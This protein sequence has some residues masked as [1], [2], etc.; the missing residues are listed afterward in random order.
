[1]NVW[2]FLFLFRIQTV[3]KGRK[4]CALILMEFG[5]GKMA[6]PVCKPATY[7]EN[8]TAVYKPAMYNENII[9]GCKPA[10]FSV[11]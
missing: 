10:M 5:G 1:M 7:S 11:Q 4:L 2:H 6:R 3:R 9:A 8:I